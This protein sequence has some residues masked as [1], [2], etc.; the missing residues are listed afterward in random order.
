MRAL[1]LVAL[2]G[3]DIGEYDFDAPAYS[4]SSADG[5]VTIDACPTS[6]LLGCQTA[7][8]VAMTA[9]ID[10]VVTPLPGIAPG[11]LEL[12][13]EWDHSLTIV[14][15]A[16]PHVTIS[17][18]VGSIELEEMRSFRVAVPASRT[19]PTAQFQRFANADITASLDTRCGDNVIEYN[20][21]MPVDDT[22][23]LTFP[24]SSATCQH[25]LVISQV[26]HVASDSNAIASV[27]RTQR[28]TFVTEP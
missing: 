2:A 1:I 11:F 13:P 19:S 22:L 26:V 25:T 5:V 3:C 16:D 8:N 9:V 7:P 10:G 17:G 24:A 23:P 12:F 6:G 28:Y 4:L 21:F 14:P 15:P 20:A 18:P 27:S